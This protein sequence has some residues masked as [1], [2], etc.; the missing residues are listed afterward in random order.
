MKEIIIKRMSFVNF[1]GIRNL[2]VDFD[3]TLTSILGTN[4][5]GKTS[6]FDG[7]TWLLFGK[8]SENRKNF[9]IK[10]L[11]ANNQVIERIP[12]EVSAIISVN[13]EEISLCRRFNEK[14]QKRRGSAVEEFNGNEEERLFNEVPC[15]LKEWNDKIAA[16]CDEQVFKFITNPLYFTAQKSDVQRAMLFRMAGGIS[17]AEIASGNEKFSALLASLTGKSMEEY[18]KEIAAKK[19]RLKAEIDALPER[20]DERRRDT[21]ENIDYSAVEAEIKRLQDLLTKVEDE[22]LDSSKKNEALIK[23]REEMVKKLG[24]LREEKLQLEFDIKESLSADYRKAVSKK[25]EITSQIADLERK[26]ESMNNRIDTYKQVI[27]GCDKTREELLKE[28]EAIN[29]ETLSFN[30]ADF[31]CPTCNRR[32]EIYEIEAKQNEITERFNADKAARLADNNR[33][34]KANKQKKEDNIAIINQLSSD[35]GEAVAKIAELRLSKELET[36][37]VAPDTQPYIEKSEEWKSI[38]A[39]IADLEEKLNNNQT[40][41]N[42]DISDLRTEKSKLAQAIDA[43]KSKLAQKAIAERNQ[44]RIVE[45]E[46]QLRKQ[47]EELAELEGI[48]FTISEFSKARIEM[49]ERKINGMFSIVK[50][51]MFDTLINGGEVETCEAMVNGVP[52]SDLN[53]AMKINSGLDIINAIC[54]FEGITAPVFIDN[55]EAVNELRPTRSQM[56]RLVVTKDESLIIENKKAP[57][58]QLFQ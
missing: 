38:C 41:S 26:V 1:K 55:A 36:E 35:I 15:S 29:A 46:T 58:G 47:N 8:D 54:S 34:G 5:V 2:T 57:Q 48:E 56:I 37:L 11:D 53:N 3:D 16:L 27:E 45:L 9:N 28:W 24:K 30:E 19:R 4:G 12:H 25:N 14:W 22:L 50:F 31:I 18:K 13:G 33:K 52:F 32:F 6:I 17:D 49:V 20:I 51:K 21:P 44:A 10:T 23:E 7:F 43:E 42:N 39:M 40:A